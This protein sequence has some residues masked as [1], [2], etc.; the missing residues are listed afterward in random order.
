MKNLIEF[1]RKEGFTEE[2]IQDKLKKLKENNQ[3]KMQKMI[4]RWQLPAE[5]RPLIKYLDRWM[6]WLKMRKLMKYHLRWCNNVINPAKCDIQ[7]AFKKW[8]QSDKRLAE[9]LNTFTRNDIKEL[10]VK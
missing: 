6:L 4:K 1:M 9:Y 3:D 10:S 8:N 7:W 2:E 5:K